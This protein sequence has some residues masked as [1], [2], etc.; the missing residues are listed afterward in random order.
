MSEKRKPGH[1]EEQSDEVPLLDSAL[2]AGFWKAP[3]L[4]LLRLGKQARN[5]SGSTFWSSSCVELSLL[6][7]FVAF[8]GCPNKKSPPAHHGLMNS[9]RLLTKIVAVRYSAGGEKAICSSIPWKRFLS[10]KQTFLSLS[11]NKAAPCDICQVAAC[12][13]WHRVLFFLCPVSRSRNL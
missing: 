6:S 4:R 3:I 9:R 5:D 1:C 10:W 8:H 2:V 12:L 13:P 7:V 11:T